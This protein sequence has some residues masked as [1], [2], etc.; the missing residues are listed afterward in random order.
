M[1]SAWWMI[2]IFAAKMTCSMHT[3]FEK[4]PSHHKRKLNFTPLIQECTVIERHTKEVKKPHIFC[5]SAL[6]WYIHPTWIFS[7]T[8]ILLFLLC[9]LLSYNMKIEIR[10]MSKLCILQRFT[11]HKQFTWLSC[12]FDKINKD[13]YL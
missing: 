11:Y 13:K 2:Q 7:Y 10:K 1:E 3:D 5:S 4:W 12:R 6:L 8:Y 9:D